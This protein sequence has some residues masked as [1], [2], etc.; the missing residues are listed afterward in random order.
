MSDDDIDEI[1]ERRL[2]ELERDLVQGGTHD[3]PVRVE[4]RAHFDE[5]VSTHRLALV[6]FTAAWCG[7]CRMLDPV[8][9]SMAGEVPATILKVDIDRLQDI[10]ADHGVRSVPT[11]VLYVDGD[12]AER[13][14]GL[15][16]RSAYEAAIE[17]HA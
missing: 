13:M 10:A 14:V 11:L 1:R 17:H 9:E 4:D 8:L 15:R 16:D 5:L 12:P 7:P 6:D 3:T 2:A